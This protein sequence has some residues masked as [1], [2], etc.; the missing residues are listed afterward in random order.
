M[1]GHKAIKTEN[2]Y[3]HATEEALSKVT[4]PSQAILDQYKKKNDF[5]EAEYKAYLKL[6]EKFENRE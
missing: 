1:M 2:I 4:T 6:K 5:D 3:T